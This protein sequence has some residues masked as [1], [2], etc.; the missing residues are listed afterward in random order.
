M[1]P[2][3]WLERWT[4]RAMRGVVAAGEPVPMDRAA[5]EAMTLARWRSY[6]PEH[7]QMIRNA[8]VNR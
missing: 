2:E 4:L 8:R 5:A 3:A 6:P 1:P 7:K